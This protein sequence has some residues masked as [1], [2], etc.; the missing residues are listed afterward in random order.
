MMGDFNLYSLIQAMYLK[1]ETSN[2]EL[3]ALR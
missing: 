3:S 2:P 1:Q